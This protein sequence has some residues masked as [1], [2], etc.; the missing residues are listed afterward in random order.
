[1]KSAAEVVELFDEARAAS[2]WS[3]ER[4][5][6]VAKVMDGETVIPLPELNT[7]ELSAVANLALRGQENL[8]QRLASLQPTA[9]SSPR[10]STETQRQAA[11]IRMKVADFWSQEDIEPLLDSQ[12]A[13]YL[14]S[15]SQT[16]SRIDVCVAEDRPKKCITNPLTTYTPRPT[17]VNDI[18]PP[19]GI[20]ASQMS[21]SAIAKR[22]GGNSG[23]MLALSKRGMSE[24]MW[25][26]EYADDVEFHMV[27]GTRVIDARHHL[28]GMQAEGHPVTLSRMPNRAGICPWVVPSLIGLNKVQGHFDQ[29]LGM[30]AAQ[31]MLTAL[32]LQHAARSVWPEMWLVT[33][34]GENVSVIAEADPMTGQLGIIQGG[35]IQTIAPDPQFHT[36]MVQDRLQEAAMM[37]AGITPDTM[38]RGATNVRT[39]ARASQILS[40]ATDPLLQE[41]Q[42]I[43][44]A[45]R[46]AELKRQ[47]AIDKAYF[48]TK[49]TIHV[50]WRGKSAEET[51]TPSELWTTDKFL[52][53]YPVAGTDTNSLT[54]LIGQLMGLDLISGE[55]ARE[56]LP[57]IDDPDGEHDRIIVEKLERALLD[58]I[59]AQ[60]LAPDSAFQVRHLVRLMDLVD[61]KDMP[62]AKAWMKVQTEAQEEQAA[63]QQQAMPA[64]DP[65]GMPGLDGAGAIPP[66]V[67]GP[68]EGTQNLASLMGA[69]RMPEMQSSTSAGGRA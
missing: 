6:Q 41:A 50:T 64:G 49:K 47:V 38:G 23:V 57:M 7:T 9:R 2:H 61:S 8:A 11:E 22:W 40:A 58:S 13:R 27:L 35:D 37:G 1:M 29:I 44:Q 48:D 52:V 10:S 31:S 42:K 24:V 21:V 28:M 12:R 36:H 16:P 46:E 56:L 39:G 62:L 63:Q 26:L 53:A 20:S 5:A 68:Q 54:I 25:V 67:A 19:W 34:P 15:Y 51:Y 69:L 59:P 33:R 66:A 3:R 65:M 18:T 45:G 14:F 60:I 4:M 32:E 55:K 30:Y 17:Q 43:M